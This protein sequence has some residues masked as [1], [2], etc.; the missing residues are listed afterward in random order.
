VLYFI[1]LGVDHYVDIEVD[2]YLAGFVF[3]QHVVDAV[4]EY[5]V[6]VFSVDY[7]VLALLL[8]I[9]SKMIDHGVV[10]AF[11]HDVVG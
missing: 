2:H 4:V 7:H 9:M 11:D 10:V 3:P 5:V 8:I 6:G 1:I